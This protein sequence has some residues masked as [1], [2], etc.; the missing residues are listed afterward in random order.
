MA[1][2]TE[3]KRDEGEEARSSG[4]LGL[5]PVMGEGSPG[6]RVA[7]Q[8]LCGGGEQ[9]GGGPQ[10]WAESDPKRNGTVSSFPARRPRGAGGL[11]STPTTSLPVPF[12][13]LPHALFGGHSGHTTSGV[14]GM[15]LQ[16]TPR[17]APDAG[18]QCAVWPAAGDG[19]HQDA[20]P[21]TCRG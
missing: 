14:V 21:Q 20:G 9:G 7:G 11:A 5:W 3:E 15:N 12:Y 17:E 4:F 10:P 6:L 18:A 1:P 16:R 13:F 2:K 19:Q 8:R